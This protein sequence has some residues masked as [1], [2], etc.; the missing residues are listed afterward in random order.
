MKV[1]ATLQ[2]SLAYPM[3]SLGY[4]LVVLASRVLLKEPVSLARW[5]AVTLICAGVALVGLGAS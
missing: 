4:V 1:L 2:L 3:V 5:A